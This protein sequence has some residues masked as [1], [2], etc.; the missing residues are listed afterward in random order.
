M[1]GFLSVHA[2]GYSGKWPGIIIP[3]GGPSEMSTLVGKCPIFIGGCL[4]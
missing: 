2:D 1:D 3:F 4:I